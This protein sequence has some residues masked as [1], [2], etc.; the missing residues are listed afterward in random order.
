M[1]NLFSQHSSLLLFLLITLLCDPAVAKD[2]L[3]HKAYKGY[4]ILGN[5]NVCAVYSDDPRTQ[6]KGI[7][8]L[9]FSDYTASYIRSTYLKIPQLKNQIISDEFFTATTNSKLN[10]EKFTLKTFITKDGIIV[11]RI[12]ADSKGREISYSVVI[13]DSIKTDKLILLKSQPQYD[14]GINAFSF[15]WTDGR[16]MLFASSEQSANQLTLKDEYLIQTNTNKKK[17]CDFYI[18]IGE[19]EVELRRKL[20]SIRKEKYPLESASRYW[21]TWINSGNIPNF[22]DSIILDFYKRNLYAAYS[23]NLNGIIPADITGQFVTN[24]MPQLYPRDAL[25]TARA[26]VSSGH[27]S[28]AVK[29]LDFWS[30]E[31]I[32]N[33]TKG[34]LFARYDANANAVDAGSG[35]KYDVP[36]WDSNSYFTI[37]VY[38]IWKKTGRIKKEH[39][40]AIKS[41]LDFLVTKVDAN[42]LLHEGGIIEWPGYLPATNMISISGLRKGAEICRRL[43]DLERANKYEIAA[44][45]IEANLFKMFDKSI[46]SYIDLRPKEELNS[47]FLWDTSVNFGIVWDYNI[48]EHLL[49]TNEFIWNNCRKLGYGIQYFD[50]PNEGLAAYGHDLFFFTTSAAAQYHCRVNDKEKYF[51]L[52]NWM[53]ENSNSYRLMPERIYLSGEDCSPASPLSWC[54]A[55]FVNALLAG[56]KMGFFRKN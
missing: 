53:M 13:N 2:S 55:E 49:Q 29:V 15:E 39:F 41:F 32:P 10:N 42:G 36:E 52:I 48:N 3:K 40:G 28:S 19:N 4:M 51:L 26:F 8:R 11:T 44:K 17:Y 14:R 12:V 30:N 18:V 22:S 37:L 50:S 20:N 24:G 5:G 43:K 33:K 6:G 16:K 45:F 54:C 21:N 25:M 1:K 46:K 9:Y 56:A 38:E 23:S 7:Q 34:E 27:I 47:R 31:K 35:A